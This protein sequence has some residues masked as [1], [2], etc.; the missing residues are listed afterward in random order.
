MDHEGWP[1]G[2]PSMA[3]LV[4]GD[5]DVLREGQ[6][7][8]GHCSALQGDLRLERGEVLEQQSKA[9]EPWL[10]SAQEPQQFLL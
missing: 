2:E 7:A 5:L 1:S 9:Y 4:K 10:K 8:P 6:P 3:L